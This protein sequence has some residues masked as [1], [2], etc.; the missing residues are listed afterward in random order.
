MRPTS[1]E[2]RPRNVPFAGA[3]PDECPTVTSMNRLV[4][5]LLDAASIDS[6][7]LALDRR[8]I[9]V[10]QLLES[11][12]ESFQAQVMAKSLSLEW[13]VTG[14]CTVYADQGRVLQLL[15]NL[16]SN[17][18]RITPAGGLLEVRAELAG[19]LVQFSVSDTGPGIPPDEVPF[20][21]ERFWQG[22]REGRG[23][24][25]LGLAISRGIVEG[26]G[27]RIWVDSEVD[28]GTTFFF[29][30]PVDRSDASLGSLHP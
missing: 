30:L 17:A 3:L 26:H 12:C 29:T 22:T 28:R 13:H 20:L 16:L 11:A 24:A 9:D 27:G 6:G 23:S 25:G 21:F 18:I 1:C 5:D 10:S 15:G 4:R 14:T 19:E 8:G 2:I 7:R